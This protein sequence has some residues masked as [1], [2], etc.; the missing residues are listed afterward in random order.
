MT[1]FKGYHRNADSGFTGG[2]IACVCICIGQTARHVLLIG[3]T[4]TYDIIKQCNP[5]GEINAV[6]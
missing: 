3:V 5:M 4:G 2:V 6:C 1:T